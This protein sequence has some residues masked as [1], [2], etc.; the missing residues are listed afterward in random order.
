MA[1][2]LGPHPDASQQASAERATH[3]VLLDIDG[4]LL[5]NIKPGSNK[6]QTESFRIALREC[7]GV[8]GGLENVEHAG[9]TLL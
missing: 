6:A 5:E 3:I 7:W 8:E 9:K 4:T 1:S 2:W